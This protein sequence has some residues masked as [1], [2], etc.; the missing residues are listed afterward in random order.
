MV[1]FFLLV[2]AI[3]HTK[4]LKQNPETIV[5]I[6]ET[7][8]DFFH[9]DTPQTRIQQEELFLRHCVLASKYNKPLVIHTR[10]AREET[11]QFFRDNCSQFPE[12]KAVIHCFSEDSDF[13]HEV[14]SAYGFSLGIGGVCTYKKN[15]DIRLA[16]ENTTLQ[17]LVT[18][19]DSPYLAPTPN[20]GK[21]NEPSFVR[22]VA[23][24][25]AEYMKISIQEVNEL[26]TTNANALFFP[27]N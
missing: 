27:P 20:R 8:F 14:T 12:L 9:K 24:K 23:E 13:A 2:S 21:R 17:Y 10:G 4:M 3:F 25:V 6:G 1:S 22:L 26:T 5:G 19:T 18:E 15:E 11:L 16:I 7:G